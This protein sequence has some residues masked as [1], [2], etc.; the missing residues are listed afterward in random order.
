M[1]LVTGGGTGIGAACCA[2]A[3]RRRV[4]R[5][6]A[7]PLER[8]GGAGGGERSEGAFAVQA[9][10][11]SFPSEIEALVASIAETAG[12][13]DVLVNNAGVNVTHRSRS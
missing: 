13:L 6:G 2:A 1:A 11:S 9:P 5:R 8:G 7:L 3:R 10:T 12:R 4:P